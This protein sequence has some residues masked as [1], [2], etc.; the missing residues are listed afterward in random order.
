MFLENLTYTIINLHKTRY[1]TSAKMKVTRYNMFNF[2]CKH[3]DNFLIIF[4][5]LFLSTT[6]FK[7]ICFLVPHFM[8]SGNIFPIF[9]GCLMDMVIMADKR[10]ENIPALRV[11]LPFFIMLWTADFL[12]LKACP[13][14]EDPL[15]ASM[16][17]NLSNFVPCVREVLFLFLLGKGVGQ[18]VIV[19]AI[20]IT[21]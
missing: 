13:K 6:L 9:S 16:H 12:R 14:T 17:C 11:L 2:D 18:D 7:H 1:W 15:S 3:T 20:A 21:K 8:S 4:R 5:A 10:A 19:I